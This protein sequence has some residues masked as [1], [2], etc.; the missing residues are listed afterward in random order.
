MVRSPALPRHGSGVRFGWPR[1]ARGE[2][3]MLAELL[4]LRHE[5]A[6]F[7]A[8]HPATADVPDQSSVRACPRPAAANSGDIG[9]SPRPRC[10][11]AT[12]SWWPGA[13]PTRTDP[14]TGTPSGRH[15]EDALVAA[16][17]A[18][19]HSYARLLALRNRA[20]LHC[21]LAATSARRWR[22]SPNSSGTTPH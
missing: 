2:S 17:T 5:V 8:T 12:V 11:V 16:A 20:P 22:R 9:S 6:F 21:S 13:G 4:V 3:A 19:R 14:R 10:C 7:A 18:C 1:L 15:P